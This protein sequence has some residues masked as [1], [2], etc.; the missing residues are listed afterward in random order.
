VISKHDLNLGGNCI[1]RQVVD[2][3]NSDSGPLPRF[4]LLIRNATT[5]FVILLTLG[6]TLEI[7]LKTR[8]RDSQ[9]GH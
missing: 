6:A 7:A 1:V 9:R 4:M 3:R 8:G 5:G 2:E